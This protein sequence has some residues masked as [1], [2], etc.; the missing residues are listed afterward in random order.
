MDHPAYRIISQDDY[1][2][3]LKA[4]KVGLIYRNRAEESIETTKVALRLMRTMV[5]NNDDL[6]RE[7][8]E[9]VRI[10]DADAALALLYRLIRDCKANPR[11]IK[12]L[13]MLD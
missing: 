9:I 1:E 12:A 8:H 2:V 13:R 7:A 5:E 3:A 6:A 11:S 10:R 4:L